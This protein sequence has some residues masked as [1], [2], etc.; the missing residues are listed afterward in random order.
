MLPLQNIADFADVAKQRY[1]QRKQENDTHPHHS[2]AYAYLSAVYAARTSQKVKARAE[3][4]S[5]HAGK[6]RAGAQARGSSAVNQ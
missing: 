4:S 1:E 3:T 5:V 2:K 6:A